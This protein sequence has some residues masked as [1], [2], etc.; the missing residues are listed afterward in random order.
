MEDFAVAPG[1]HILLSHEPHCF[2]LVPSSIDLMLSG[3]AH[4]GQWRLFGRGV[5]APG[6]GWF[7]RYSKGVYEGRLVVSAGLS[8]TTWVPRLFNPTEVV[9]IKES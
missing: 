6:Q 7:P 9:Y 3:H 2:S 5:F 1:Y 4:G 8:N